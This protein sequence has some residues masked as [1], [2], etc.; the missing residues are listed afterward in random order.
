MHISS[1]AE[2]AHLERIRSLEMLNLV[3]ELTYKGMRMLF[4]HF[5]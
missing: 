1:K 5:S 3:I 2:V 4:G